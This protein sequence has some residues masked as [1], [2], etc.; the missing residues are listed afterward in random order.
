MASV[1]LATA[2]V[3]LVPSARGISAKIGQEMGAPIAANASKAGKDAGD[4]IARNVGSRLQANKALIAGAFGTALGAL[5]ASSVAAASDLSESVSKVGVVFGE[6][7]QDIL[8]WASSAATSIG[9]SQQQALEAAGT[10][11]NLFTA[12]KIGGPAAAEMSTGLVELASDLASFNNVSPD[13]AL[14]ALRSGLTGETEPLKR[15]GVNMNDATLKAKALELGIAK[16]TGVLD[17]AAKAQAAYALIMEQT[18]TAQGDFARTS[19]GLANQQRIMAAQFENTKASL[20]TALLPVMTQAAGIANSLVGAFNALPGPLQAVVVGG[21]AAA[22]GLALFGSAASSISQGASAVAG[23]GSSAL[24]AGRDFTSGFSNSGAAA[25]AFS[26]KMGTLGGLAR[27]ALNGVGSGFTTAVTAIRSFSVA[28]TLAAA[29][30]AVVRAAT[31]AWTAAQWLF[32]AALSANP[33]GLVVIAIAALVAGFVWLWNNSEGFRNFWIGLWEAIQVAIEPVVSWVRDTVVPWLSQAWAAISQGLQAFWGVVQQ[34][35]GA[36]QPIIANVIGWIQTYVV[37]YFTV[38]GTV[39]GAIFQAIGAVVGWVWGLIGD[40]ILWVARFVAP[41]VATYFRVMGTVLGVIFKAIAAVVQIA[42]SNIQNYIIPAVVLIWN[43]VR[44]NFQRIWSI[45]STVF[46]AV[47]TVIVNVWGQIKQV[48]GTIVSVVSVVVS[49]FTRIYN[50][51]KEKITAAINFVR[52]FPSK[53]L[54]F[55]KGAASMLIRSGSDIV[56]GLLQGIRDRASAVLETVKTFITDKIPAAVKKLMGIESPAK[57][58]IPLGRNITEGVA[59]GIRA[60][61]SELSAALGASFNPPTLISSIESSRDKLVAA[62]DKSI[63]AVEKKFA[64]NAKK[65]ASKTE[66]LNSQKAML[67]SMAASTIAFV[68]QQSVALDAAAKKVDQYREALAKA[69]EDRATK[70]GERVQSVKDTGNLSNLLGS[71]SNVNTIIKGLTKAA[72]TAATFNDN[73]TTAIS[74]GVSQQTINEL[75]AGGVGSQAQVAKALANAS[76]EQL[77]AVKEQQAKL[78]VAG[79]RFAE[80]G[81]QYFAEAGQQTANGLIAGLEAELPRAI[82]A[83]ETLANSMVAAVKKQL[84]IKSPSTVFAAIGDNIAQGVTVGVQR[85]GADTLDAITGLVEAPALASRAIGSVSASAAGALPASGGSTNIFNV[86]AAPNVPT[87]EQIMAVQRRAELLQQV[88]I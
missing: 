61:S 35:W 3:K 64:K 36:I 4:S 20:G 87:E 63:K 49:T 34:V 47:K 48:I 37:G 32:N 30:M 41:L 18:K 12:L 1:E 17:P 56:G 68:N 38:L 74:R 33:I 39:L 24:Q 66:A 72:T 60:G 23:I 8:D 59:V 44:S 5:V 55:F 40:K 26:G 81:N 10:F 53:I 45:A 21:A 84:G 69:Q 57:V 50:A 70:T 78:G 82:A 9:Q 77:A 85:S 22:G 67:N 2:Y 6:N 27:S 62:V 52:S 28:S 11:G 29:R 46:N 15:F 7:K 31:V 71:G 51:I 42:W 19:D 79:Q 16:G 54:G 65:K 43:I 25:S 73:L 76:D 13:E 86:T 80:I 88:A 75:V 14:E 83:A 58:M